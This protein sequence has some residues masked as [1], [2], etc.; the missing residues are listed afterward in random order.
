MIKY[1]IDRFVYLLIINFL[2]YSQV[3]YRLSTDKDDGEN[4][5]MN[6][7]ENEKIGWIKYRRVNVGDETIKIIVL[8]LVKSRQSEKNKTFSWWLENAEW[9]KLYSLREELD[10]YMYDDN[11][12]KNWKGEPLAKRLTGREI[13]NIIGELKYIQKESCL[14]CRYEH[15]SQDQH[16]WGIGCLSSFEEVVEA[17]LGKAIRK[18]GFECLDEEAIKVAIL[19]CAT[20]T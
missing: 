8:E 18:L 10:A 19:N 16:M 15:P 13:E 12:G 17:Y 5:V 1:N 9:I 14:G 6:Q 11:S 7:N 20:T 4:A 3:S 2:Y